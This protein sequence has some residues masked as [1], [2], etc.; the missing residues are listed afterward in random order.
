[1]YRL[2]NALKAHWVVLVLSCIIITPTFKG[3]KIVY[4]LLEALLYVQF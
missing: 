2:I 3:T 4:A 1:M